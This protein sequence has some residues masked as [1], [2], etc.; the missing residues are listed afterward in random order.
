MTRLPLSGAAGVGVFILTAGFAVVTLAEALANFTVSGRALAPT[1]FG[2]YV[3]LSVLS[4]LTCAHWRM[5]TP[6]RHWQDMD[7][8]MNGAFASNVFMA[9]VLGF[10]VFVV[11]NFHTQTLVLPS[12]L[13][14]TLVPSLFAV[15]LKRAAE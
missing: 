15:V 11:E 6:W 10:E 12:I 1:W 13:L 7:V 3:G 14:L 4:A 5:R 9:T 8:V 2:I